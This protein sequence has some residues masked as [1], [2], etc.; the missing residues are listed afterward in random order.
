MKQTRRG[1]TL[2]ELL[3][4]IAIIAIL[5][6]ILFPVFAQAKTAAKK[7]VTTSNV[8]QIV[9]ASQMYQADNDDYFAPKLRFGYGPPSGGDA[10]HAM[11]FEK[12][13]QPYT[14]SWAVF[15]FP[16]DG[17]TKFTTPVGAFR[18]S[19]GVASHVFRAVQ[20][21][22]GV[23]GSF[24]GKGSI[25]SSAVPAPGD[26]VAIAEKRQKTSPSIANAWA[27]PEW[28]YGIEVNHTRRDDLPTSDPSAAY[29][30]I[31]YAA[32]DGATFGFVDGHV[33][34][35][36]M[37]GNRTTDGVRVGVRFPGY[38]EKAAWWVGNPDPFW[39]RGLSCMD[40]G[41]AIAD[42]DCPFPEGN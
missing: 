26:T 10:T 4:V 34:F 11:S 31:S 35:Q 8:K 1:F 2:I 28:Y 21:R 12:I 3:V 39:D 38:A 15:M 23:W 14:K 36:V 33:K 18:R 41:W 22:P 25:S 40:S 19:F 17:R 30:D 32:T 29:G 6:A 20:V 24:V 16:L 5:A 7:A 13:I 37:N 27:A 42:G 9:L